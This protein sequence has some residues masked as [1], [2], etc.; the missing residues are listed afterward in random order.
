[1]QPFKISFLDLIER[2]KR[3]FKIPVY[4]RNYVWTNVQCEKLYQD[5]MIAG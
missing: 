2:N 5:I 4:Q 3:I 1:M